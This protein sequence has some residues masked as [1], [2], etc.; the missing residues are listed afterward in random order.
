ML[1]RC[2]GLGE[3]RVETLSGGWRGWEGSGGGRAYGPQGSADRGPPP[4]LLCCVM[5]RVLVC[6]V[7][8][9][10]ERIGV[11]V[12]CDAVCCVGLCVC[13]CDPATLV[14]LLLDT[15]RYFTLY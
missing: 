13:V 4:S 11:I 5:L 8:L 15:T 10:V 2:V 14:T 12:L 9:W 6:C 7:W 3:H 1:D